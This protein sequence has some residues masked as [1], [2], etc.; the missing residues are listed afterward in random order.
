MRAGAKPLCGAKHDGPYYYPT[1]LTDVTVNMRVFR[2]ETFGPVVSVM[3]AR[4]AQE[5]V[6]IANDTTYGLTAGIITG[7]LQKGLDLAERIESGMVHVNDASVNDEPHCP[8]GGMKG[9]GFGRHGGKALVD[10]FTEQRWIT[11]QR[12]PR[13]YPF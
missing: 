7:D 12:T 3:A 11:V 10:E 13:V 1:V 5:A 6:R 9:S 8:F 2:E 4:D